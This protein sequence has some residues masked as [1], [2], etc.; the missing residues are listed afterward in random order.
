MR[1]RLLGTVLPAIV[2][3][4]APAVSAAKQ[5]TGGEVC[6]TGGCS[7][8]VA[9]RIALI[10]GGPP[11]SGPTAGEPFV[12][13]RFRIGVPGHSESVRMLFL[14]RSGLVLADDGVTWMRPAALA[15]MRALAHRVTAFP[16]SSLPPSVPLAPAAVASQPG[17]TDGS[18]AWWMA[19]PA[20]LIA[21]AGAATIARHRRRR[22]HTGARAAGVTG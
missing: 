2:L 3:L 13:M 11:V 7:A 22:S 20:A 14:P 19:V 15:A 6:G 8:I 1:R 10:E 9:P 18:N 5:L 21:L 4:G 12:R 16:A 17:S